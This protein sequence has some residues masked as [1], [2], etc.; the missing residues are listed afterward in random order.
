M[1]AHVQT[2]ITQT[3][4]M[5]I[6]F[7]STDPASALRQ[8]LCGFAQQLGDDA[9]TG[10]IAGRRREL[11]GS[12]A[13]GGGHI[14]RCPSGSLVACHKCYRQAKQRHSDTR[15]RSVISSSCLSS[16]VGRVEP[17][18]GI[19]RGRRVTVRENRTRSVWHLEKF[20]SGTTGFSVYSVIIRERGPSWTRRSIP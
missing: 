17:I 12:E 2:C 16:K 10:G 5:A 1:F 4:R 20:V 3:A 14:I 15:S 6:D 11:A 7:G 9:V 13:M 19:S 8:P 18:R